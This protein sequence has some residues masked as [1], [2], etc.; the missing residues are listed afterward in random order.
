MLDP[1]PGT[2]DTPWMRWLVVIAMLG[3]VTVGLL[4]VYA[5]ASGAADCAAPAQAQPATCAGAPPPFEIPLALGVEIVVL[6][7][8][9]AEVSR[10]RR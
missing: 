8:V 2:P 7:V 3:F 4:S 5:R 6:A 10:A 1:P 9:G